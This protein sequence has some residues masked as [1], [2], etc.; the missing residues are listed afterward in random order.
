MDLAPLDTLSDATEGEDLPLPEVLA[1]L[2]GR[3]RVPDRVEGRPYVVGNFVTTL[4]GVVSLGVPGRAGGGAI[5]GSNQHD[6]AVMGILRAASDAVIV[7]AGTLRAVP[8]HRWTP[9]YV[10]PALADDYRQFRSNLG[11][12]G[13]PLN[14]IVTAGGA[15]DVELPVFQSGE[16][17]V[18][19]VTTKRGAE[20][21]ARAAAPPRV[22]VASVAGD[23]RISARTV[24]AAVTQARSAD[25]ILVEGGPRLIGDFFAEGCL[26]ELFLTLAPQI[27]GRDDRHDRPGLVSGRTFAPANPLWATLVSLKRADSHLFLRYTFDRQVVGEPNL[28]IPTPGP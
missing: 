13:T 11:K 14:V 5:S 2:Y 22:R 9:E 8:N 25:Q 4:D 28:H 7:G 1:K 18:L 26:D 24:L 19:V 23:G 10:A 15:I 27:A 17:D 16:V 20:Q 12:Q 3:L 6:R 21:I